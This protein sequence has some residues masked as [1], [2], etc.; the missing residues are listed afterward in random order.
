M[1]STSLHQHIMI[2][3]KSTHILQDHQMIVEEGA[4]G[5]E[6]VPDG[7]LAAP[8]RLRTIRRRRRTGYRRTPPRTRTLRTIESGRRRR[9]RRRPVVACPHQSPPE[10]TSALRHAPLTEGARQSGRRPGS[11]C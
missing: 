2:L 7:L 5:L 4:L 3:F 11:S 8:V 1:I 10:Q 9:V 6:Q